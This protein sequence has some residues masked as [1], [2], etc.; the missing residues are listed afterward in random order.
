MKSYGIVNNIVN[1]T[2]KM[3]SRR[4]CDFLEYLS[5]FP[6]TNI[7]FTSNGNA[8]A[9]PLDQQ[10]RRNNTKMKKKGVS[11]GLEKCCA[12]AVMLEERRS[13]LTCPEG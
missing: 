1:L 9:I 8:S 3:V 6:L 5:Q 12:F 11:G 4:C 10:Y 13:H 2:A 7:C